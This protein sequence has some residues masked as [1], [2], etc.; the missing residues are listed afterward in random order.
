SMLRAGIH[1]A[2]GSDS[3]SDDPSTAEGLWSAV[4]RPGLPSM[5]RLT[6][7]EALSCYTKGAAYA[8]FS[9]RDEGTLE[10]GKWANMTILDRDPFESTLD[11]LRK[12][13]VAQTI[14]RGKIFRWN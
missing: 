14:V 2:A 7:S 8:S 6:P 11:D 10:V 9:E 12:L 4:S 5:E 1:L 13:R 3:P